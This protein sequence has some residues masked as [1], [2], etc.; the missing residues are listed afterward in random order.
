[1]A[2]RE[3]EDDLTPEKLNGLLADNP[4][5]AKALSNLKGYCLNQTGQE[6]AW[7]HDNKEYYWDWF[8]VSSGPEGQLIS[9]TLRV[10]QKRQDGDLEMIGRF[11]IKPDGKVEGP[12][13]GLETIFK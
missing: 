6:Y 11:Q 9:I 12:P 13:P 4:E 7:N 3:R 5:A 2:D 10:Q 8:K 1:M